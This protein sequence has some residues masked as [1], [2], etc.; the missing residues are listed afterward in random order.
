MGKSTTA[1]I[2][3]RESGF[4]YYEADCFMQLKNPYISLDVENPSIARV[5]QKPLKGQK[6]PL[7]TLRHHKCTMKG[8]V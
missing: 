2:L 4:V 1:Q 5:S 3:A 6:H 8:R 7:H